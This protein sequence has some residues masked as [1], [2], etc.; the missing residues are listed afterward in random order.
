MR[1]K[2][3]PPDQSRI[4]NEYFPV[5][6]EHMTE[7]VALHELI[8]DNN[9]T[10][11][12]YRILDIN[13]AYE[14]HT[15][16]KRNDA[17]G[18]LATEVYQT[19]TPPYLDIFSSAAISKK[20]TRLETYFEPMKRHFA[21]SI[22]PFG[23]NGFATIFTDITDQKLKEEALKKNEA[24]LLRS[25]RVGRM[26]SYHLDIKNGIWDCTPTLDEIFGTTKNPRHDTN[27]WTALLHPD[28]R[29]KM[30][31]YLANHVI[32]QKQSFNMEYRIIRRNDGKTIWVHGLGE[33]ELDDKGEVLTMFGTIQDITERKFIEEQ[34]EQSEKNLAT[35]FDINP[36]PLSIAD[37]SGRILKVNKAFTLL[38]GFSQEET[39]GRTTTELGI[40]LST[41]RDEL[42]R[43]LATAGN[44]TNTEVSVK[45]KDGSIHQVLMSG[46]L[47]EM[48]GQKV[49][50][51]ASTDITEKVK[52]DRELASKTAELD[53]YF[54][55][56]LDLLC[57]ANTDG[58]FIRLN[59]AWESILGYPVSEL[60]GARFL[61][62]VHPDDMKSTL[63]TISDLS[64]GAKVVDF[65]NRYRHRD[66]SW[67]Y[68]EWRTAPYEGGIIYA[69]ARDITNRIENEEKIKHLNEKLENRISLLTHPEQ[70]VTDISFTDIF[71]PEEIQKIQDEFSAVTGVASVITDSD[72][73]PI[74]RS[75]NFS[76]LCDIIR[77][78]EEGRKNC[79][80]SDAA[81]GRADKTNG[82]VI[83]PCLSGG[84]LDG[85]TSI[86]VGNSHIANWLIGQVLDETTD[87]SKIMEYA[88]AIGADRNEYAEALA[89]I[90][91]MP[92][93]RFIRICDFLDMIAK[94]LST[95]AYQNILQ[96]QNISERIRIEEELRQSEKR[97]SDIFNNSPNPITLTRL[98]DQQ[99]VEINNS[100]SAVTGYTRSDVIGRDLFTL[101]VI[102]DEVTASR[103]RELIT[104]GKQFS[105]FEMTLANR[106]GGIRT[107][108]LSGNFIEF[109][110]EMH[111]LATSHDITELRQAQKDL[112][113]SREYLLSVSRIAHIGH[114][115]AD[116]AA[117][118]TTWTDEMYTIFGRD[119]G[120]YTPTLDE[121]RTDIADSNQTQRM[122]VI[123][124]IAAH[125][126]SQQIEFKAI[127]PDGGT[128]DCVAII[129]GEGSGTMRIHGMVQDVT[130]RKRAE[131][132]RRNL[133]LKVMQAQKLESLGVLAGGIAHDFNNLLTSILGNADL[134][135]CEL[136]PVSGAR[137]HVED[138]EKAS[139]RAAELC[140]QM[141]AYSGKGRFVIQ[142]INLNEMVRE[143]THLLSISI[144][145]KALI[146]Y[147]LCEEI[148][149]VMGDVT[150]LRQVVMNLITNASEAIG[151]NTGVITLRTGVT[152]VDGSDSAGL[153]VMG[154]RLPPGQ[155]VYLEVSDTG[156]GM[157]RETSAKIFDPFF[158]TKFTGRGLGL[159]AVLGIV[160]GHKG[161]I[162]LYSEPGKGT[163]FKIMFPAHDKPVETSK[164]DN[165][166]GGEWR[167]SGTVLLVD[168]EE[169]ILA[170]GKRMLESSGFTVITETDGK[171]ALD[172]FTVR[173]AGIRL[174]ILDMT[175][176]HMDGEACFRELMKIDPA[177]KVIMTSGYNEQDVISRFTGRGLA[178][179]IQKP[180]KKSDIIQK[181]RKTLESREDSE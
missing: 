169:T 154:D 5:L 180:Y 25:Q 181:I 111:L 10:P 71:D 130:E 106:N 158:T 61:D 66:G 57:I 175:M 161:G 93:E 97:L 41:A 8:C 153:S 72:G 152:V 79:A 127:R 65:V 23:P 105:G 11:V 136:S 139:V 92:K 122:K 19:D 129:E 102:G 47:A 179:F 133:E 115:T 160:R 28:D 35:I 155:Y 99:F 95:L 53:R 88:D 51:I 64:H 67:R 177:V 178:G 31:D 132:E 100:F 144:S 50:V 140:R 82:A 108:L 43:P 142:A 16:L 168:D 94:Q 117:G 118:T 36:N 38:S 44:F 163:T 2:K 159:A 116:V 113:I 171:K 69:A 32:A 147:D 176:P 37:M 13:P 137:T 1:S 174:V 134:A 39:I 123:T 68:I 87:I 146:R 4:E 166:N 58:M 83:Y 135:L 63:N 54:N 76:R 173:H 96:A 124:D 55:L 85:G 110:G 112:A 167:G 17:K 162:H 62:F 26:G 172:T 91:R 77:G 49:V 6:F 24:D 7:G 33:L 48:Y 74:T 114:F 29:E 125:G 80:R 56:S 145:K 120:T 103:L 73:K 52:T 3:I 59:P 15:G 34:R 107:Y 60:E 22:T 128:R 14:L 42:I 126:G 109:N 89:S 157:D 30:L 27:E 78:T 121:I 81:L 20:S 86:K 9:G 143:M 45:G 70:T 101:G 104:A 156:H 164:T 46:V 151:D 149:S 141:L 75:S 165:E 148:Q 170:M 21:I 84:L 98:S 12:N 119:P 40:W 131:E 138:I 90:P 150:Q 18:K